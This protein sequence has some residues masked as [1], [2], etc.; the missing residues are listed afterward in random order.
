VQLDSYVR[1][2]FAELWHL[3]QHPDDDG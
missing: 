1:D 3:A 2:K